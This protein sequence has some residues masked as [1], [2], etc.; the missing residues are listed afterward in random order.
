MSESKIVRR[1]RLVA[2][3]ILTAA[4]IFSVWELTVDYLAVPQY[5]LPSPST[6][7]AR[8]GEDLRSGEANSHFLITLTEVLLGIAISIV[9]GLVLGTLI[10]TVS[11]VERMLYPIILVVQTIPKVAV[12][13]LMVIWLGYG[14]SSKVVTAALISFFPILVNVI[15]GIRSVDERRVS[16]MRMLCASPSQIFFKVRLP[17]MLGYVFA[18][19]EV[20]V[21]LALIGAIV[22]EF[23]GASMGIGSL[24]VQRQS[25]IDVPGVFSLLAYLSVLGLTLTTVVRLARQRIVFWR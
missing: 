21:V 23:V 14:I 24:I 2:P 8:I 5:I 22:G 3:A 7:A 4:A 25:Q 19:L 12:A 6:I 1:L 20:G 10:G 15:T 9:A 16:L 18:G 11:L 17:N 13:P